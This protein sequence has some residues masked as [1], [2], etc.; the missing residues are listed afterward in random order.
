[1]TISD[2]PEASRAGRI[3][4]GS[5]G[6][7]LARRLY[8]RSPLRA[9][10]RVHWDHRGLRPNDVILASY[11]RSGSAW[12]RFL[13]IELISGNA[14]FAR[15]TAEAG[16]VGRHR[17]APALVPGGGRLVKSHEQY[18]GR[19]RRAVHLVR[20]P[21]DVALSYF[22]FMQRI[23]RVHPRP[24]DD[25]DASLDRFIR[26]F[27]AGHCDAH[28][29]WQSHLLSWLSASE[30]GRANVLRVRYEDLRA[31]APREL[32]RIARWLGLDVD[33]GAAARTV[34]RCSIERMRESEAIDLAS[35]RSVFPRAAR[36]SG[37]RLVNEGRV[38]GWREVLNDDQRRLFRKAF[39]PGL[40]AMGYPLE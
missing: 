19:Y 18:L 16:Y 10:I 14:S 29:T 20:D 23:G 35:D 3:A 12:L 40:E 36:K 8:R 37:L 17:S 26:A 34:E 4:P 24:G 39:A 31:D 21:R 11:P 7:S 1:V 13:L 32:L 33:A 38:G 27:L 9:L 30:S 25:L 15:I 28:G 5:N 2:Q 6:A 22:H